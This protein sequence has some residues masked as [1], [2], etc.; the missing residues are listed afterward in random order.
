VVAVVAQLCSVLAAVDAREIAAEDWWLW[1]LRGAIGALSTLDV[2]RPRSQPIIPAHGVP[3]ISTTGEQQRGGRL[4]ARSPTVHGL[5]AGSRVVSR[6]HGLPRVVLRIDLEMI[7]SAVRLFPILGNSRSDLCRRTVPEDR[8]RS[9]CTVPSVPDCSCDLGEQSG[10]AVRGV[11][12]AFPSPKRAG[13]RERSPTT[14]SPVLR[15]PVRRGV[16]TALA[17]R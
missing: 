10:G 13:T 4:P 5:D 11:F 6:R 17:P 9:T 8:E 7:V 12:P 16:M 14:R 3:A 15:K 1:W 2:N